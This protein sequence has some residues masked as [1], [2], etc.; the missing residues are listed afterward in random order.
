MI[1]YYTVSLFLYHVMTDDE[2]FIL[3]TV[4]NFMNFCCITVPLFSL[5]TILQAYLFPHLPHMLM[6]KFNLLL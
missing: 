2:L 3:M 4:G 6:K 5:R 1:M